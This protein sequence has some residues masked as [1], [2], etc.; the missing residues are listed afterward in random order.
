[1][2]CSTSTGSQVAPTSSGTASTA[3][4]RGRSL[5]GLLRKNLRTP[6]A[7]SVV[8]RMADGWQS[9]MT[10]CSRPT[11]PGSL[12]SNSGTAMRPEYR[13]PKNAMRYS[14][15]CGQRIATRSPGSVTC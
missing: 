12:G 4:T 9:S 7:D 3:M 11:W 13:V 14:R 6:S 8:V 1:M 15:F 10:A 2:S 5:A